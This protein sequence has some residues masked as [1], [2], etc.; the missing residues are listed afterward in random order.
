LESYIRK[1]PELQRYDVTLWGV[2]DNDSWYVTVHNQ[3]EYALL[4]NGSYQKKPAYVG[5]LKG[6]R[7]Q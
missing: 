4:F 6:F 1:V 3:A 7:D 2:T 5:F